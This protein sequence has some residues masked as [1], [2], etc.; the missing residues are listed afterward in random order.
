MK[1]ITFSSHIDHLPKLKL[2]HITVPAE[3]VDKVGGIG[4]RLMCSV[5]GNKAFHAGMVA[6]GGGAAYI[7]V[8]KKRMKKYGIKKGDEVEATI[9]LDNSKYGMEMPEELEALLEQDDEGAHRFEMLTPG[10]Q[11]YIIHYVSQVKSS[12]KKIDRAIMLINNLKA[13]PEDEFDFRK[14]LGLPPRDS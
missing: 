7:T 6:L 11:R 13:L 4:T 9:E 14:L 10:K 2:H 1:P 12:Q 8:N 5:N 3:I